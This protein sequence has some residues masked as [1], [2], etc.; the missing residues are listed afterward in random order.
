MSAPA[1]LMFTPLA[2]RA[3]TARNRVVISPMQQ[4]SA[5]DGVA[6][7]WHLIHLARF[8][9]GGAGIVFV[10]ATAVEERGRNTHGH[11]GL[12]RDDQVEPLARI[13]HTLRSHRAV[14]AIQLGHTGRKGALQKWW[15]GHGP[16]GE[17]DRLERGEGPWPVVGPSALPA[18]DG[19]PTPH[20]LTTA[21]VGD[22]VR[23]YGRAARRAREAGFQVLEVHGAHGYLIHQ[24]MSP[25]SNRRDDG[26]GGDYG[27]WPKPYRW[28]LQRRAPLADPVRAAA[29]R[30]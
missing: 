24:F 19:Y 27:T 30:R 13:A 23:T 6:N 9:L 29:A 26:Y 21:E 14:A 28:W 25:T 2:L 16:L 17:A 3:V 18:G 8:A 1:V 22:L 7:D 4:Y 12:W 11:L 15:E 20:A 5:A 10:G